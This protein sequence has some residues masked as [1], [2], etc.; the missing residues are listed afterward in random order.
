MSNNSEKEEVSHLR[1]ENESLRHQLTQMIR[2][3]MAQQEENMALVRL[4]LAKEAPLRDLRGDMKATV[5]RGLRLPFK[6]GIERIRVQTLRLY[7]GVWLGVE[8]Q[9]ASYPIPLYKEGAR[10]SET[11]M[12]IALSGCARFLTYAYGVESPLFSNLYQVVDACNQLDLDDLI[13]VDEER[14]TIAFDKP[15]AA[16]LLANCPLPLM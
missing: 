12:C 1:A 5:E 9:D 2:I 15:R 3:S 8:K 4:A 10:I 6:E 13:V 14:R 16:A 11:M 7:I